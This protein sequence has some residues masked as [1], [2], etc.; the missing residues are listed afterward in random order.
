MSYILPMQAK[1]KQYV[2]NLSVLTPPLRYGA[3]RRSS[4]AAESDSVSKH[5]E[6]FAKPLTGIA[7][8]P[9]SHQRCCISTELKRILPSSLL[10]PE[11]DELNADIKQL[12]TAS[13]AY[14]QHAFPAAIT[15]PPTS[16]N[17]ENG[18][19][20]W[21]ALQGILTLPDSISGGRPAAPSLY[22]LAQ[23]SQSEM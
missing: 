21:A 6:A 8:E 19:G 5:Q 16:S 10:M 9:K 15:R 1:K 11:H 13:A 12:I 4:A 7:T 3:A 17:T 20:A 22:L 2:Q 18:D 23:L 14:A